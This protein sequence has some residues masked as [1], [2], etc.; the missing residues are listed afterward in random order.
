L[1]VAFSRDGKRIVSGSEDNTIKVWDAESAQ[2]ALTLRGHS[3]SVSCVAL[4]CD[5]KRMVSGSG[6]KT[7]KVWLLDPDW[8]WSRLL[9]KKLARMDAQLVELR[10]AETV[11]NR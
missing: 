2:L 8:F 4:S 10:S 7:I 1:S 5:G 11:A 9:A 6:D 3:H